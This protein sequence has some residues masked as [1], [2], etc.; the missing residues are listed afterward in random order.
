MDAL[1]HSA[2]PAL[3]NTNGDPL[4]LTM[5]THGLGVT[6]DRCR[7][8]L[9]T[10]TSTG[11]FDSIVHRAD[12]YSR[13]LEPRVIALQEIPVVRPTCCVRLSGKSRKP[14]PSPIAS[15]LVDLQLTQEVVQLGAC[16]IVGDDLSLALGELLPSDH[17]EIVE[18]E[19]AGP[20][21]PEDQRLPVPKRK[22]GRVVERA[23]DHGTIAVALG[24]AFVGVVLIQIERN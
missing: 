7:L 20:V 5:L 1:L 9:F 3:Q 24:R 13:D 10:T 12:C 6:A 22:R 18:A 23:V 15:L 4:E 2:P 16:E 21:R 19:A 11:P 14:P 8:S 17:V